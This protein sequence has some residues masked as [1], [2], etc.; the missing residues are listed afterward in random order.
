MK[1]VFLTPNKKILSDLLLSLWAFI[2]FVNIFVPFSA[3]MPDTGLDPSWRYA[4]NQALAQGINFGKDIIFTFG[5]YA[6]IYTKV[7]HPFVYNQMIAGGLFIAITYWLAFHGLLKNAKPQWIIALLISSASGFVFF[8]DILLFSYPVIVALVFF[9]AINKKADINKITLSY[10]LI[11]FSTFGLLPLIKGNILIITQSIS[12]LCTIY[13]LTEYKKN[14][15]CIALF[16]P[17]TSTILFWL[18]I[19]Q[20]FNDLFYYFLNMKFIIS[21]YTEAM[22]TSGKGLEII[23]SFIGIIVFS[24]SIFSCKEKEIKS[25]LFLFGV[26]FIFLFVSFKGSFVRHDGHATQMANAMLLASILLNFIISSRLSLLNFVFSVFLSQYILSHY[27]DISAHNLLNNFKSTYTW[28][29]KASE[30]LD[31]E[32]EQALL[33]LKKQA[34]FPILKGTTDIYE[35]DISYLLASGNQWNPRPVL[36]SYSAYTAYL[37]EINKQHLLKNNVPDNIIF[38]LQAIDGR[39]PAI[40]DG[41]S[42]PVLLANYQPTLFKND[43]LFL[44]KKPITEFSEPVTLKQ[45]TYHLGDTINL[46]ETQQAVFVELKI[47]PSII[48]RIANLLY[49]PSR[50]SISIQLKNGEIKKYRLIAN[51]SE[52]GFLIS[53]FIE[54]SAEYAL[55]YSDKNYLNAK[56]V[57]SFTVSEIKNSWSWSSEY[58]VVFK[59]VKI[60]TSDLSKLPILDHLINNTAINLKVMSPKDCKG[61][62]YILNKIYSETKFLTIENLLRIYG[63]LETPEPEFYFVLSNEIGEKYYIKTYRTLHPD[64][65]DGV[66]DTKKFKNI[67]FKT[68]TDIS[69]L[70][71]QYTLSVA[72]KNRD[73]IQFCQQRKFNIP[74]IINPLENA[75][76][77]RRTTD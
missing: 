22:S 70:H 23:F 64:V 24:Y 2:T 1:Q 72:L 65:I 60:P 61:Q 21:G 62:I 54:D 3:L 57:K 41:A 47:K 53:P 4:M 73:E 56:A 76:T 40:E 39:I 18:I 43:Y 35:N 45:S 38:K 10:F 5:P 75:V 6:S 46:P 31:K 51:M 58:N 29:W 67:G 71:G 37:A 14:I 77:V 17:I 25:R 11:L 16:M 42:W 19:N 44:Q 7:Y 9:Q 36:Q 69:S 49:K 66:Y 8:I 63:W 27:I 52:S 59:E 34:D 30:E 50:L 48:G 33:N 12:L 68:F 55:L 26:F 74:V 20:S 32:Y 13:A 28:N 15:A